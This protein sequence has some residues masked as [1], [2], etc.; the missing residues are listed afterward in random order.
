MAELRGT[1]GKMDRVEL[2]A[3]LR[4]VGVSEYA[5]EIQGV[6]EPTGYPMEFYFL[7]QQAGSWV[8]GVYERG[9]Y[10]VM[11]SFAQEDEACRYLYARLTNKEPEPTQLTPEGTEGILRAIEERQRTTGE[12][13]EQ[14]RGT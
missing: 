4:R 2:D 14:D 9:Q 1:G 3:A 10:R 13:F 7:Q 8:V 11:V 12:N 6:H 5:Y